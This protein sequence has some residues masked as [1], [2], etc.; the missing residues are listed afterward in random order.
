[1]GSELVK[2]SQRA[3]RA[4]GARRAA[5]RQYTEY[6][7]ERAPGNAAI[8]G[9]SRFIH[10]LSGDRLQDLGVYAA[11]T[12]IAHHKDLIAGFRLGGDHPN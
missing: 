1:M 9:R 11:K 3:R 6:G 8:G 12:A 10:K 5:T 2:E 7:E 4:Q